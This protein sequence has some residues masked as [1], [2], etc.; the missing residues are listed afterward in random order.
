MPIVGF[1]VVVGR[2]R[3]GCRTIVH[4]RRSYSMH[5]DE[6]KKDDGRS[7]AVGYGVHSLA[8]STWQCR[9][10]KPQYRNPKWKSWP[11]DEC[12]NKWLRVVETLQLAWGLGAELM[13][14]VLTMP[15][16]RHWQEEG[17]GA[18]NCLRAGSRCL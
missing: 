18:W 14:K 4:S 3:Q 6:H 7:M 11:Q 17:W 12:M 5:L 13:V 8:D 2:T 16:V 9:L 15:V 1:L 10:V